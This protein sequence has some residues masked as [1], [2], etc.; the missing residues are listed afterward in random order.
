MFRSRVAWGIDLCAGG[1]VWRPAEFFAEA[2][3]FPVRKDAAYSEAGWAGRVTEA[4][5]APAG[6][7]LH[8]PSERS[9]GIVTNRATQVR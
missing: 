4:T 6:Q 3:K 2:G 5:Y 9:S 7:R 1:Q 8:F